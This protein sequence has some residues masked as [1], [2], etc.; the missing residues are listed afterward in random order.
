M[1]ARCPRFNT[2]LCELFFTSVHLSCARTEARHR[3]QLAEI[4]SVYSGGAR[5][6]NAVERARSA[7]AKEVRADAH[8][9]MWHVLKAGVMLRTGAPLF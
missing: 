4:G 7:M 8:K 2:V 3:N 9:A 6:A 5:H 1:S